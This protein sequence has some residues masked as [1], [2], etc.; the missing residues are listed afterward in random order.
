MTSST[1]TLVW[2]PPMP[3]ASTI[4]HYLVQGRLGCQGA[5]VNLGRVASK[6]LAFVS[7]L[8]PGALYFF[9]VA[10]ISGTGTSE[11]GKSS[12]SMRACSDGTTSQQHR[13][14]HRCDDASADG[15]AWRRVVV[16]SFF[17]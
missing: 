9:R 1:V 16:L 7:G 14:L 13:V 10:A 12:L 6:T 17:A 2:D 15:T 11:P 3:N 4:R 5:W 8:V